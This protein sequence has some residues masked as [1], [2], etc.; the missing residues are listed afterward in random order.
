MK[1]SRV[2]LEGATIVDVAARA[3]VSIATVSRVIN[4]Y[5]RVLPATRR[6]VQQAIRQL[7][8]RPNVH[9]RRLVTQSVDIIGFLLC[10]R[11]FLN[12]FHAGILTGVET[13]ASQLRHEV[14][15]TTYHYDRA[16]PAEKLELP[17]IL[18]R[19]GAIGGVI[20]AG[21]NYPNLLA[22]VRARKIPYIVFGNNVV[23]PGWQARD[24]EGVFFD[25]SHSAE[26][27]VEELIRMGHTRIAF[28]GDTSQPWW[29]RR[30]AAYR[31]ALHRH[32]LDPIEFTQPLQTPHEYGLQAAQ[33]L[34]ARAPRPTA[35][36]A[37]NDA[38]AWGVLKRCRQEGIRIPQELSLVGF[39]N[40][41]IALM[42][43]PALTT[44]HV[45]VEE[46]GREC[47]Q[48]ILERIRFPTR[49]LGQR[50]IATQ[51]VSRESWGPAPCD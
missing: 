27:M 41:E 13:A 42:M 31:R 17:A 2:H 36:F 49:K 9:A 16:T 28:A 44:V 48:M 14:V 7:A 35:I 51:I 10:N 43:D 5:S 18:E 38:I 23:G 4:G 12:R 19:A 6:R 46:I 39:D 24:A 37:G 8:Y 40:L 29:A 33:T 22:A 15:Y 34:L 3:G 25:D 50:M 11:D 21:T 30:R 26:A 47:V 1:T 45:P 32:H 20:I